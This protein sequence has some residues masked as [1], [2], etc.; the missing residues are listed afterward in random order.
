[1]IVVVVVVVVVIVAAA[2][3]IIIVQWRSLSKRSSSRSRFDGDSG[4]RSDGRV[5]RGGW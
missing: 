3:I 4:Y 2:I 1:M 5:G